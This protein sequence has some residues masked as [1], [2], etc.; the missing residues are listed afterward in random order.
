MN[1]L[2]TRIEWR[3]TF[4]YAVFG[5][6][7]IFLS[8]R[9]LVLWVD[10]PQLQYKIQNYKG[11]FFVLISA[12]LIYFTSA[13]ALKRQREAEIKRQESQERFQKLFE[14]NLDAILK[15][16]SKMTNQEESRVP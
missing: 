6:L 3:I 16:M 4:I 12:L 1:S 15:R 2:W 9:L 14:T 5:G 11:W 8:D 10:D 13:N 7:W